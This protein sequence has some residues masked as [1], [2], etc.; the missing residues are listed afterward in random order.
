MLLLRSQHNPEEK[1]RH[2]L[3][4]LVVAFGYIFLTARYACLSLPCHT[5]VDLRVDFSR[6]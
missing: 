4:V 3:I 6:L 1:I 2:A 5:L